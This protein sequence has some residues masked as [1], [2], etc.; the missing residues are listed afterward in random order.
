MAEEVMAVTAAR[1]LWRRFLSRVFV[2]YVAVNMLLC[3]VLFAPWALPRET[4]SGLLGRWIVVEHGFK[5]SFAVVAGAIVDT[6][7]FWEPN[8]CVAVYDC[9]QKAREVLYP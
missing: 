8:H 6:I 3:S 5:R 2:I 9:E 4:I 1:P 7:Y